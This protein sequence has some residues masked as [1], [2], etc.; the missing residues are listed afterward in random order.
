MK[1]TNVGVLNYC[2][3]CGVCSISCPKKI[4]E[5]KLNDRGF[6]T[7]NITNPDLCVGLIHCSLLRR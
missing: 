2:F 5:L 6:Y 4:I 7:P 3:G 1:Y